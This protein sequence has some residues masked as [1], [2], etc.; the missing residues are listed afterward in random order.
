VAI[1]TS[2]SSAMRALVALDVNSSRRVWSYQTV[3][4]RPLGMDL[5]SQPTLVDLQTKNGV[6]PALIQPTKTGNLFVLD[7]RNG[8]L[9]V[10]APERPVLQGAAPGD[11]VASTQP[12]LDDR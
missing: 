5:P 3:H 1:A 8:Q 11:H 2:W 10:P 7:R 4:Q 12:F 9:I 6:V